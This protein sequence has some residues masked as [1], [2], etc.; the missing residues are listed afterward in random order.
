MEA[1]RQGDRTKM[2]Q[3][4]LITLILLGFMLNSCSTLT[5]EVAGPPVMTP[6][7]PVQSQETIPTPIISP[8]PPPD[9]QQETEVG[10]PEAGSPGESTASSQI[11][12]VGQD[13]NLWLVDLAGGEPQQLTNDAIPWGLHDQNFVIT[14][15]CASWSSDGKYLA[16][17]REVGQAHE[18][19]FNIRNELWILDFETS[20]S[21]PVLGDQR[22]AGFA[23]K[24]GTH[25][26]AFAISPPD[27][28]IFN[29]AGVPDPDLAIGIW[30]VE[31][32]SNQPFELV[33]PERGLSLVNPKF[34]PD[35]SVLGFEEIYMI[36][37]RGR[38]AYYNFENQ[39]Y[40][41]W[42][43]PVGNYDWTVG[44]EAIAFDTLTYTPTGEERIWLA[45]RMGSQRQNLS[46]HVQ[47]SYAFNPVYSPQ[48]DRL[49]YLVDN[50]SDP[51]PSRHKIFVVSADGSEPHS[52]GDYE[53]VFGLEWAPSGEE[54]IFSAGPYQNQQIVAINA[55]TGLVRILA[56]GSFPAIIPQSP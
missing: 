25:L 23:W 53:Q 44:G 9:F 52:L 47:D 19:G 32:G 12:Y 22:T 28:Y 30:A 55:E 15:C 17:Q 14:Y 41:G 29:R 3:L 27:G 31:A 24:P 48:G 26:L 2:R 45:D 10:S 4:F 5:Q 46:T 42:D 33:R 38:F 13:S 34:S 11:A 36:E 35:G 7:E 54:L 8:E 6:S 49:A 18:S 39:T 16:Y 40:N 56:Q 43:Q 1:N 51:G 37:G 50:T 21:L 20:Q